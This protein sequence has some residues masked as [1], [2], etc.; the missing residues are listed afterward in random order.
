[1]TL[2]CLMLFRELRYSPFRYILMGTLCAAI[3]ATAIFA[4]SLPDATFKQLS[5]SLGL[6]PISN[7]LTNVESS[8]AW[9]TGRDFFRGEDIRVYEYFSGAS[10]DIANTP[11]GASGPV[12]SGTLVVSQHAKDMLDSSP[13]LRERFPE[14]ISGIIAPSAVP[15][16]R[17]AVIYRGVPAPR[18]EFMVVDGY[19]SPDDAAQMSASRTLETVLPFLTQ[20]MAAPLIVV[21]LLA[22]SMGSMHRARRVHAY[23]LL[24][25]S[26][27]RIVGQ[28]VLESL[29]VGLSGA[30]LGAMLYG[31]MYPRLAIWLPIGDGFYPSDLAPSLISVAGPIV[32]VTTFLCL[33]ACYLFFSAVRRCNRHITATG[34]RTAT[35]PAST[36]FRPRA[37]W[38][39]VLGLFMLAAT[40]ALAKWSKTPEKWETLVYIG[41]V[42]TCVGLFPGSAAIGRICGRLLCKKASA[43]HLILGRRTVAYSFQTGSVCATLVLVAILSGVITA[44]GPV[45]TGDKSG[46]YE[47]AMNLLGGNTFS[48]TETD[49]AVPKELLQRADIAAVLTVHQGMTQQDEDAFMQTVE[50]GAP[51]KTLDRITAVVP[52]DQWRQWVGDPHDPCGTATLSAL[53]DA[54]LPLENLSPDA[55]RLILLKP[56]EKMPT[57]LPA[58]YHSDGEPEMSAFSVYLK[59]TTNITLES[60]RGELTTPGGYAPLTLAELHRTE[61]ADSIFVQQVVS[62]V[63]LICLLLGAAAFLAANLELHR[64][65]RRTDFMIGL[66]GM[67]PSRLRMIRLGQVTAVLIPLTGIGILACFAATGAL[68]EILYDDPKMWPV[69]SISWSFAAMLGATILTLGVSTTLSPTAE[70]ADLEKG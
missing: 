70:L 69:T 48:I 10:S 52:C 56:G 61:H 2:P 26:T 15:G 55:D 9:T 64:T 59:P 35:R 40:W 63:S 13:Q 18:G 65:L 54:I 68:A 45:V 27:S 16:P 5:R 39:F 32:A 43:F 33:A 29:V 25:M 8:L 60:L 34:K 42:A 51:D 14:D 12:P 17:A 1:M 66:I 49:E 28:G 53:Q 7:S 57:F 6:T 50:A 21:L 37:E 20:I 47:N 19:H 31:H 46:R 11:P 44:L 30:G 36:L 41:I 22:S 58:S 38:V 3:S 62:L 4:S 24:G 67:A 23:Q